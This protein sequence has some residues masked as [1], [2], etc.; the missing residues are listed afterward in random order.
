VTSA[1]VIPVTIDKALVEVGEEVQLS[2]PKSAR[3]RRTI[4]LDPETLAVLRAYHRSQAQERLCCGAAW[5][6]SGFVFTTEDG[7]SPTDAVIA[8]LCALQAEP[9]VIGY[10]T[11][12]LHPRPGNQ[13]PRA[14]CR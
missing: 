12:N 8:G 2:E 1:P 6:D 10:R 9:A 3:G 4:T 7:S 5:N 13:L 14:T 11:S